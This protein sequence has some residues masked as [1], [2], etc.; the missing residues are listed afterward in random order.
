MSPLVYQIAH[1]VSAILL[2]AF[3]ISACADPRPARKK[4][5]MIITGILSLLVIVAGF[6]LISKIYGNEFKGWMYAKGLV[7][8]LLAGMSGLAFR[9]STIAGLLMVVAMVLAGAAVY[10]VYAKPVIFGH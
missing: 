3:V 5:I 10:L 1:V 2:V 6:G 9:R 4:T 8:L 7:W